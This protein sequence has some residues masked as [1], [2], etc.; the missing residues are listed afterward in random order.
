MAANLSNDEIHPAKLASLPSSIPTLPESKVHRPSFPS[1]SVLAA[2]DRSLSVSPVSAASSEGLSRTPNMDEDGQPSS[3]SSEDFREDAD[4]YD[5][6][7]SSASLPS[8]RPGWTTRWSSRAAPPQPLKSLATGAGSSASVSHNSRRH[9]P[10]AAAAPSNFGFPPATPSPT[11]P[12]HIGIEDSQ[13]PFHPYDSKLPHLSTL[14]PREYE[15]SEVA[16]SNQGRG[17][18]STVMLP[19]PVGGVPRR[20][21][22]SARTMSYSNASSGRSRDRGWTNSGPP[23]AHHAEQYGRPRGDSIASSGYTTS[24]GYSSAQP[25]S[26]L[27]FA[28][29][30]SHKNTSGPQLISP[31]SGSSGGHE[32]PN[33]SG[34]WQSGKVFYT[35]GSPGSGLRPAVTSPLLGLGQI[36]E[37]S[38]RGSGGGFPSP[39]DVAKQLPVDAHRR[40]FNVQP[41]HRGPPARTEGW[42]SAPQIAKALP[43]TMSSAPPLERINHGR[44]RRRPPYSYSSL[45]AQ[46][47]SSSPAGRM[48]LREIYTW[49]SQAYPELY[50][51]EGP[52]SLGWQNTVRHNLSLNKSF[53]KIARTAQDIYDSCASSNPAT[54][55]AARG[56]GG[57]WTIDPVIA[58]AQLGP[59]LKGLEHQI[60]P[61]PSSNSSEVPNARGSTEYQRSNDKL[62]VSPQSDTNVAL[63]PES[64][65][66]SSHQWTSTYPSGEPC[67]LGLQRPAPRR[68]SEEESSL[69]DQSVN[70]IGTSKALT[71]RR[72]GN[73]ILGLGLH[74]GAMEPAVRVESSSFPPSSKQAQSL[75]SSPRDIRHEFDDARSTA[76]SDDAWHSKHT[77]R[78]SAHATQES[79]LSEEGQS[80]DGDENTVVGET[81][82]RSGR[83]S[84]SDLLC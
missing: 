75:S 76:R 54:S 48:T 36:R 42:Q 44:R 78:S 71:G 58:A 18:S 84:I 33:S 2:P 27:L 8:I 51:M 50:S 26:P 14:H 46:A 24:E 3:S 22:I 11:W 7:A 83:M 34:R 52:D 1:I 66:P 57:W 64:R 9:H 68:S 17:R 79:R 19:Q 73:T 41:S 60:T 65:P 15:Y 67:S 37:G 13:H 16:R 21:T 55:Q 12:P 39:Y 62:S 28:P 43:I 30:T 47:I 61:V 40:S 59:N 80:Q 77:P 56:K 63:A 4:M 82:G 45:I 70:G 53:V 6:A 10:Y 31:G 32:H 81:A 29:L 5:P 35:S 38:M 69:S 74:T 72:R 23:V 25:T 20:P 49:I